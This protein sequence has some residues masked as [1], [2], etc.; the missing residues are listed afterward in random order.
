M[1]PSSLAPPP[2][3]SL[4]L[5]DLPAHVPSG[6]DLLR[7]Q[8]AF[9]HRSGFRGVQLNAAS[10]G[11]RPRDLDRSARRDVASLLKRAELV[12]SGVDLWIP[13]EHFVDPARMDRAVAA[14]LGAIELAADLDRL[15]IGTVT[16]NAAGDGRV[17]CISLPTGVSEAVLATITENASNRGARV[18]DFGAGIKNAGA[19][20]VIGPGF[21]PAAVLL[22]SPSAPPANAAGMMALPPGVIA[23]RLTDASTFGRVVPGA[24]GGRLDPLAYAMS[25]AAASYR[26]YVTLDTRGLPDPLHAAVAGKAAWESI[27]S[28]L[29]GARI[30]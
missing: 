22:A 5:V 17:V 25:L 19:P 12:L 15:I 16:A 21:D 24:P 7:E 20:G 9:A 18:A 29:P 10:P 11:V 6:G 13:P 8:L 27:L 3:L 14:T 23:A 4:A 28:T 26:G 1:N 30:V 2:P